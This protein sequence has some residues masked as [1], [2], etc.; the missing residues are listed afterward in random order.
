MTHRTS[1]A[2]LYHLLIDSFANTSATRFAREVYIRK[3]LNNNDFHGRVDA[4]QQLEAA[5]YYYF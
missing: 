1:K 3:L 2:P 5:D 4:Y